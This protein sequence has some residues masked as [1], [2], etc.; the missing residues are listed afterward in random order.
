MH[1]S[2]HIIIISCQQYPHNMAFQPSTCLKH[3]FMMVP[4]SPCCHQFFTQDKFIFLFFYVISSHTCLFYDPSTSA[5]CLHTIQPLTNYFF[6]W[7][8]HIFLFSFLFAVASS[9]LLSIAASH[10]S[11][12]LLSCLPHS[13]PPSP[14]TF[15]ASIDPSCIY[16]LVI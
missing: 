8:V 11:P 14:A 7:Y 5:T 2:L 16:L 15:S 9:S 12:P 4:F 6:C 3:D 10:P 1:T 13:L